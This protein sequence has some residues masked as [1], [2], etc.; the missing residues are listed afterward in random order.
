[1]TTGNGST[2]MGAGEGFSTSGGAA[3]ATARA[4]ISFGEAF[5]DLPLLTEACGTSAGSLAR[6]ST[7]GAST[8]FTSARGDS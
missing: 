2:G 7:A 1:M 3:G 4:G 5:L 8:G 6:N